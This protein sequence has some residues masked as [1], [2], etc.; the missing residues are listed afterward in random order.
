M[1]ALNLFVFT[2][3]KLRLHFILSRL[4]KLA[5]C[6]LPN[7]ARN[8]FKC[9]KIKSVC[10]DVE[11]RVRS[12]AEPLSCLVHGQPRREATCFLMKFPNEVMPYNGHL[13]K[14]KRSQ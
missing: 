12:G 4:K 5:L 7:C 2:K 1:L 10:K 9:R 6:Q 14:R 11:L 3:S 8:I 13:D